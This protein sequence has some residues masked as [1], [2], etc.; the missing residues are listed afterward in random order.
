MTYKWDKTSF[1]IP[2]NAN[3]FSLPKQILWIIFFG[4]ELLARMDRAASIAA[5]NILEE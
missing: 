1:Q 2:D 4:G 5:R 3:W